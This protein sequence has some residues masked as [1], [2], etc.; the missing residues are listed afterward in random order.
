[1]ILTEVAVGLCI[2]TGQRQELDLIAVL[3]P[4]IEAGH[5]EEDTMHRTLGTVHQSQL[6][7]G[8][9]RLLLNRKGIGI[10]VHGAVRL[11]ALG[12]FHWEVY[13]LLKL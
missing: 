10:D 7:K 2:A 12:L 5:T 1:M 6:H 4:V 8:C 9:S 11:Y 13:K 3:S